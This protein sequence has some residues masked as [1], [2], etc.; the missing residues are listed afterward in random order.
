MA[1][2]EADSADDNDWTPDKIQ[3]LQQKIKSMGAK[4]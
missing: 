3:S 2:E 1:D 4:S